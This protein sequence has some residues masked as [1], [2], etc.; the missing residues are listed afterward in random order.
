ME[1]ETIKQINLIAYLALAISCS[2]FKLFQFKKLSISSTLQEYWETESIPLPC[3]NEYKSIE[4]WIHEFMKSWKHAF[5]PLYC[6][7][8]G[9][10]K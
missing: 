3:G 5:M 7:C 6:N 2:C 10:W 4:A 8:Q 1:V 9:T